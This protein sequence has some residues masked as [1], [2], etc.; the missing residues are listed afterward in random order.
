MNQIADPLR[1]SRYLWGGICW[2][3]CGILFGFGNAYLIGGLRATPVPQ[4]YESITQFVPGGVRTY[5]AVMVVLSVMLLEGVAQPLHA[6]PMLYDWLRMWL[7]VTCAF[8]LLVTFGFG[9]S[10][11]LSGVSTWQAM[12]Y[13]GSVGLFAGLCARYAPEPPTDGPGS[14]A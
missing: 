3:L 7:R 6:S 8:A 1:R 9:A 12:I 5:G 4:A 14:V 11:V 2:G 13:W 10:W